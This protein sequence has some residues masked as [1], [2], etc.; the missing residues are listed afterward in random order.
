MR[1]AALAA[2][3]SHWRRQPL[4]LFTLLAGLALATALWSAVQAINGEARRSYD[5]AAA[6]LGI[7]GYASLAHPDG[8]MPVA[9][10][11]ALRRDGWDVSPVIEGR[12]LRGE[13]RL[14]VTGLEPLTAPTGLLPASFAGDAGIDPLDMLRPPGV[15]FAAPETVD[16][17]QGAPGLPRLVADTAVPPGQMLTDI[18]TAEILLQK[19]GMIDRLL[20]RPGQPDHRRALEEIAPALALTPAQDQ[21]DMARLTDSFHLNLT[22]FGLLSFAV[23]LFIVHGAIGLAFEQRR[24]MFRTLR[25]LGLPARSLLALLLAEVMLLA[26]VAGSL[27]IALGYLIAGALLP[28]VAATLRGLYGAEV[29]G[30]LG[31]HPGWALAGLAIAQV[32][33]LA[34]AAHG[35]H[36]VHRMPLLASAQP[37]AWATV[38]ARA[39]RRQAVAGLAMIAAGISASLL[40]DGLAAGFALLGGV[41]LGAALLLPRLLAAVLGLGAR[42]A[43]RPLA[44]W[45]W[46]DTRQ[47]LPG[48]SLAMMALM[49]ALA[50]NIGVSTMVA[51]F[52]LTF[53]GWLDQRLVS[54]IYVTARNEADGRA[55]RSWLSGRADAVLPI[56]K[57]DLP[58]AE[59]PGEVYGIVD[60]AVYRQHWPLLRSTP[61]TWDA[62]FANRGVLINEQL[63]YRAGLS[64]GDTLHIGEGW[65]MSVVG[66]YSDYGNPVGQAV[67]G[68]DSLLAH[69]PD[70]PR[71]RHG[72]VASDPP[73]LARALRDDYGL[74]EANL[75][76]QARLKA[77]S[78]QVFERTF[79]VT[80]ALNVLTLSVAGFAILTALLTLSTMR[81]PQL[82]PVWALG[83]TRRR[84][85]RL[86]ILRTLALAAL[87]FLAA[88]PVGLALAW[89]LLAV[90]N[91]EAFGWRLPMFLFPL[92]WVALFALTLL[93]AAAAGALPTR[94]LARTA[95][96]QFLKVFADER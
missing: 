13:T 83:L 27:G 49:L 71:L 53:T 9:T 94:R 73:A 89:C 29:R 42:H 68:L 12:I 36:Q 14:R 39:L 58:L 67:V 59:A 62:A 69:H 37:R 44:Q 20:V 34:A 43:R 16:A 88:L 15:G 38:S 64:P 90:V 78:L 87:T 26:F 52:R 93:A 85:A 25:A 32:G 21:G 74:P 82:A 86:E 91:V 66:V 6:T 96:A 92:Q 47:Q 81:L 18:G 79:T 8:P 28:D 30:V 11:V 17:L 51:S 77:T 10:Y 46:A 65:T 50:T 3:L 41:L 35:L 1:R 63:S 55:L 19:G 75:I 84:L 33:A 2:L 22:A 56:W 61:D 4:Q 80:G 24:P 60:H 48:L 76:D 5:A 45:F 54:D 95:P 40:A 23:G 7:G 31:F 70:V 72:I 57:V